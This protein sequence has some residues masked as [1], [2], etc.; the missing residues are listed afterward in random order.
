MGAASSATHS[1]RPATPARRLIAFR[2]RNQSLRDSYRVRSRQPQTIGRAPDPDAVCYVGIGLDARQ[3][4][5]AFARYA[6]VARRFIL[7]LRDLHSEIRERRLEL[8][9]VGR[10]CALRISRKSIPVK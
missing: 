4:N 3:M 8:L 5:F 6:G 10:R 2:L 7:G 1:Q 9:D